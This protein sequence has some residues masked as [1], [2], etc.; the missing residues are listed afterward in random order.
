MSDGA[1]SSEPTP[2]LENGQAGRTSV[3]LLAALSLFGLI[4][5]VV[6][7]GLII[8][9][10]APSPNAAPSAGTPPV[11]AAQSGPQGERGPAGP[12]GPRGP[13]GDPG[14]R[15]VRMDCS[16]G[17]CTVGCDDDEVILTAHCGAGR[18]Q[19]S[20]PNE[21]SALCRS[22]SRTKVEIVAA[23]LKAPAQQ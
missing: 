14:I 3:W 22:Q 7:F 6:A 18:P 21:R 10:T 20:F 15:L 5:F 1:M 17:N 2:S 8:A 16:T 12:P 4:G 19:A 11:A 23:C 13:T 9:R